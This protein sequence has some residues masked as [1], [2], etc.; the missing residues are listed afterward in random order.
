MQSGVELKEQKESD[1]SVHLTVVRQQES[2]HLDY[3]PVA[4]ETNQTVFAAKRPRIGEDQETKFD[5]QRATLNDQLMRIE[6]NLRLLASDQLI[7]TEQMELIQV[8]NVPI[9]VDCLIVT[10]C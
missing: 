4:T 10:S 5:E 6:A 9:V 3:M 2:R 1:G 7:P 8:R